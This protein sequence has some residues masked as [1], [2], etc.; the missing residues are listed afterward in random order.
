[1]KEGERQAA[2][3]ELLG[4]S[5]LTRPPKSMDELFSGAILHEFFGRMYG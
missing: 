3:L 1:M 4:Q 5:G 2:V